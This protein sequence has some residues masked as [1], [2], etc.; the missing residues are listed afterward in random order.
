MN[1]IDKYHHEKIFFEDEWCKKFHEEITTQ[2]KKLNG[3]L[4]I[5]LKSARTGLDV[6]PL[7][8]YTDCINYIDDKGYSTVYNSHECNHEAFTVSKHHFTDSLFG[9]DQLKDILISIYAFIDENT[10]SKEDIE[11]L[12]ALNTTLDSGSSMKRSLEKAIKTLEDNL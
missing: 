8:S 1:F 5:P 9:T 11:N 12:K 10:T 6:I 4:T 3:P 7:C 2:L